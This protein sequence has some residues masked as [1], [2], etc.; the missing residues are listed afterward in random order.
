MTIRCDFNRKKRRIWAVALVG[1]GYTIGGSVMAAIMNLGPPFWVIPGVI[2]FAA[3]MVFGQFDFR[4]PRCGQRWGH[5]AMQTRT[6]LFWVSIDT[7]I[8]YCPFCG[9][10]IDEE[11]ED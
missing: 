10:D 3:A 7:R 1:L 11:K 2:V 4:C 5:I 6:T 9:C 8:H